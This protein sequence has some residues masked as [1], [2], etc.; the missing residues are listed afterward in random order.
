M[1]IVIS[2]DPT[3]KLDTP[4]ATPDVPEIRI[5]QLQ[6]MLISRC[7][8]RSCGVYGNCACADQERDL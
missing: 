7:G 2:G 8:D 3:E 4:T 1:T 5:R 6:A